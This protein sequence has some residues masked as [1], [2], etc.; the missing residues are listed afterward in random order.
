LTHTAATDDCGCAV[1][2]SFEHAFHGGSSYEIRGTLEN[3]DFA[4]LPL[5]DCCLELPPDRTLAASFTV[6]ISSV[7][8]SF[9]LLLLPLYSPVHSFEDSPS[10]SHIFTFGVFDLAV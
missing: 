6:C 1:V 3:D 5:F 8:F 4:A 10:V 2:S 9:N 7:P